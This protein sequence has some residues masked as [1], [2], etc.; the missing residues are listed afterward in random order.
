M[1]LIL[2][3]ILESLYFSEP[4]LGSTLK[5]PDLSGAKKSD[6]RYVKPFLLVPSK[7]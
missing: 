3:S 1:L 2:A 7:E 5:S 6:L 4:F